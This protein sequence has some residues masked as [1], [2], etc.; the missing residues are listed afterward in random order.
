MPSHHDVLTGVSLTLL[1]LLLLLLLC[2]CQALA[3]LVWCMWP[4]T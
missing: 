4:H 2:F 3:P 1:L